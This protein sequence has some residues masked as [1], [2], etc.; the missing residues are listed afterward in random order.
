L[1]QRL[2]V[3]ALFLCVIAASVLLLRQQ[4]PTHPLADRAEPPACGALSAA[5]TGGF[6]LLAPSE[7]AL[8]D[9][10]PRAVRCAVAL[11]AGARADLAVLTATAILESGAATT[12]QELLQALIKGEGLAGVR[13]EPVVGPWR[14]AYAEVGGGNQHQI[15]VEDNGVLVAIA[16]VGLDETEAA[17]ASRNL[18]EA[19]RAAPP[20]D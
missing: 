8:A 13:L 16:T 15:L 3:L 5:G 7:R 10:D 20:A 1:P 6:T 11:G 2:G 9:F 17:V 18:I 14:E 12:T 4:K 19:L